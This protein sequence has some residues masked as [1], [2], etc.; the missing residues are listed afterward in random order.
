M[1]VVRYVTLVALVIWLGALVDERFGDLV[2]RAHLLTYACGAVT[3]A[4]LFVLKFMG[5]PPRGFVIRAGITVL[6]LLL[7]LAT[8]FVAHDTANLL[9]TVDI[10][11]GLVLLIWYVRE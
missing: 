9:L 4:G 3:V 2:R 1:I 7:A 11:L 5:P 10:G 8:A 6:M